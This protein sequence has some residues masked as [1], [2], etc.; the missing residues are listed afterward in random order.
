M[1]PQ[2]LESEGYLVS[3]DELRKL[4]LW[5]THKSPGVCPYERRLE[6]LKQVKNRPAPSPDALQTLKDLVLLK[7]TR[8]GCINVGE[9]CDVIDKLRS[10]EVQE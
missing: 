6:I 5:S 2:Q 4:M 8:H 3:K 7:H 1:T 10:R 9:L